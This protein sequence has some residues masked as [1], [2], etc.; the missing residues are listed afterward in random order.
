MVGVFMG[1]PYRVFTRNRLKK[2]SIILSA[3]KP[4]II[5]FLPFFFYSGI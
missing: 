2:N 1:Y 3:A 5:L 4:N